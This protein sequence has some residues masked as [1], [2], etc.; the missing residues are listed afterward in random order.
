MCCYDNLKKTIGLAW[1]RKASNE[2][3]GRGLRKTYVQE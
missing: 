1:I 3:K 2:D